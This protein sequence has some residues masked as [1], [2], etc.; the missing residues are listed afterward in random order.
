[1]GRS[2]RSQAELA[3]EAGAKRRV[4]AAA[5]GYQPLRMK[6]VHFAS[7]FLLAL[8]GRSHDLELLNKVSVP[9][10]APKPKARI[11][12]EY[13]V[14][15]LLPRLQEQG[16]VAPDMGLGELRTL[17]SHLNAAFNNDG[18]AL[19]AAHP[20][21]ST[22]GSDFSAPS[23]SYVS[24]LSKNHGHS[25][26]FLFRV[27]G[28]SAPG[29]ELLE[30]CRQL[31]SAPPPPLAD[32][33]AP[34]VGRCDEPWEDDYDRLFGALPKSR[35]EGIANLM[36]PQTL[37]LVRLCDNLLVRR[38]VYAMRHLVIGLCAWLFVYM[39][40][41]GDNRPLLLLDAQQGANARVRAQSRA[42]Y[43]RQLDIFSRS[44]DGC[45]QGG[46]G[47]APREDWDT[48]ASSPDAFES[49]DA[50]FLDLGVRI[51]FVQPRAPNAKRKHI[52]L[53]ADTLRVLALSLLGPGE[54]MT[55]ARFSQ[56][57]RD[58]WCI[59][60]GGD[61]QDGDLLRDSGFG[62]LD[63]DEDLEPNAAGLRDL[64]VR[65]GL[66]VEPSDGLVLCAIDAEELI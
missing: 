11:V 53:Q 16:C 24:R 28:A 39:M 2:P 48:F 61:P 66:A 58:V 27:L 36:E 10:A 34:L 41:R 59:C 57:L 8:M 7:S 64:L 55:L 46:I 52:E 22:F 47:A 5:L 25:G 42:S 17:R 56:V 35:A 40:R 15:N 65:L 19:A 32:F 33:G 60:S 12:D 43:A 23:T 62:P 49:L 29:A 1:M 4:H 63:A 50:H 31:V 9:K 54:V 6:P 45:A 13:V 37:A 14:D 3:A 21:Y 44:Y 38:S 51:G 18:A 20:P 26:A 30:R